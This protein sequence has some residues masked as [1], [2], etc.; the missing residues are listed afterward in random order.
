MEVII[1]ERQVTKFCETQGD[2]KDQTLKEMTC[3]YRGMPVELPRLEK[4][5]LKTLSPGIILKAFTC[6]LLCLDT[7]NVLK[8]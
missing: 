7:V 8:I 2:Y 6:L 1:I 3:N 5:S 4:A